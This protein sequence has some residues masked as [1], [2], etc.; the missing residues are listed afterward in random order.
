MYKKFY[1]FVEKSLAVSG[2]KTSGATAVYLG[3]IVKY[4]LVVCKMVFFHVSIL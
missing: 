3:A 4:L 1:V 2:Y